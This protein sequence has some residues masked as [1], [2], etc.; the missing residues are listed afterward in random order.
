[1]S[2]VVNLIYCNNDTNFGDQLSKYIIS[3]LINPT[4]YNLLCNHK[5]EP[6]NIVGIGSY[7]HKAKNN[8][9]IYGSGVRTNDNIGHNYTN[10]NVCAVRGPLTKKYLE[11][12]KINVPNIF[13]DP[14]L[15][16]PKFYT[17]KINIK[18]KIGLIPHKSNYEVYVKK[19]LDSNKYCLI[20]PLD[21]F[22]KVIDDLCSCNCIISSSLHGLICADAYK[23]PN[24]WLYEYNLKEGDFKFKDYFMSQNRPIIKIKNLKEFRPNLLYTDGN[25]I[26]L[27]Q[28][29]KA[30]PFT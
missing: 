5:N 17:P 11:K 27:D 15:L 24:V 13:G 19:N 22:K 23:I 2:E 7:I 20:N 1:M 25:K 29:I 21:D 28:L 18:N 12:K 30:F 6:I 9:Y 26:N 14:A 3:C 10:L 4:K 16:L 8:S